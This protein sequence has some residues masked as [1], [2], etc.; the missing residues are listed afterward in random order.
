MT[1]AEDRAEMLFMQFDSNGDGVA[2]QADL[3]VLVAM[4]LRADGPSPDSPVG[5]RLICAGI[6]MW[7]ELSTS[8]CED[9]GVSRR[10]F[11]EALRSTGFADGVAVPFQLALFDAN[12]TDGQGAVS[13]GKWAH[14]QEIAGVDRMEALEEFQSLDT[15]DDG[16][17]TR[18]QYA[19]YI[20]GFLAGA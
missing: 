8:A 14:W 1:L 10:K 18:E 16:Y 12:D 15:D 7:R 3:F 5:R 9:E 11:T 17:V 13:M 20:K 2:D 4:M 19:R 6:Q